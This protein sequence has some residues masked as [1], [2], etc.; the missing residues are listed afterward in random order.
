MDHVGTPWIKA[1]QMTLEE[2]DVGQVVTAGNADSAIVGG[3]DH[4]IGIL[5]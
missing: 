1:S 2:R 5:V 4:D 3:H